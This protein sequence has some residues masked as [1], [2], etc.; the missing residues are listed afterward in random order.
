MY[1]PVVKSLVCSRSA[2]TDWN[3][4]YKGTSTSVPQAWEHLVVRYYLHQ[5][6]MFLSAFV[7]VLFSS[8]TQE[9]F[10]YWSTF[11]VL[12]W[13]P[14]SQKSGMNVSTL[15]EQLLNQTV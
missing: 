6:V 15:S 1:L 10:V 8:N 14:Q 7:C 13:D 4:E 2:K 11:K 5:E 9:K 3:M 12:F